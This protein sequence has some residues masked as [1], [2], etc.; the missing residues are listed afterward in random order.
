M[1][2]NRLASF[3]TCLQYILNTSLTDLEEPPKDAPQDNS[4][5][6][7]ENTS[8]EVNV[9]IPSKFHFGKRKWLFIDAETE[10]DKEIEEVSID[11]EEEL[12]LEE[13]LE[14]FLDENPPNVPFEDQ[15]K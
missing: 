11:K 8:S 5:V 3:H 9:E 7:T 1:I 6:V 4:S 14:K 15:N 2:D 12:A 13:E 10:V